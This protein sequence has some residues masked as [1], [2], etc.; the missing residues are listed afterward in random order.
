LTFANAT[1]ALL[2]SIDPSALI[3]GRPFR[4]LLDAMRLRT[5][6]NCEDGDEFMAALC[7]AEVGHPVA[8]RCKRRTGEVLDFA[9]EPLPQG[10]FIMT[11]ADISILARAEGDAQRRADLLDSILDNVPHGICVYGPDRRVTMVNRIYAEVMEGA[12]VAIGDHLDEVIRRRAE[13]GEY[14]PGDP[15][16]VTDEQ[17]AHDIGLPQMRRRRRPNGKAVDVRTAP[18]PDGG[19]ISVVTDVTDLTEAEDRASRRAEEL[20]VMLGSIRHG[21]TLWSRERTVVASNAMAS[22]LLGHP[23]G[24]LVPGRTMQEAI[25]HMVAR[26]ELGDG[27]AAAARAE[28]LAGRDWG[29]VYQRELITAAGRVLE[30]RS[31]PTPDGG[32]VSTFTDVTEARAVEQELRRAKEAAETANRAKSRFLATM[33]HELRTPLNAIIGFSDALLREAG[34]PDPVRIDEYAKQVNIAGHQLLGLINSILD[35][36]R[37]EAG[38][39]E[40]ADDLVD[41]TRLVRAAA[42]RAD[43][44]AQAAEIEL[45]V[46][47]AEGLP[48]LRA[49]ERRLSQA[50]GHLINNAIKFTEAGGTV[51]VVV[52]RQTGAADGLLI[53][54]ADTGIGIAEADLERVFEPFTQIDSSLARRF[55]G[56]GLGLYVSR[57]LVQGHGGQLVLRS[58]PGEGTTAEIRL[59]ADR[60]VAAGPRPAQEDLP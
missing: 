4:T 9:S 23:P 35:V 21:I 57:A 6:C 27:D 40:L 20:A 50:L 3:P 25:D 33:S 59:P 60:L 28:T 44:S 24:V 38:R 53:S 26:G 46:E 1:F 56:S 11:V 29:D 47:L 39:F 22:E 49:D 31:D 36:S 51:T 43:A 34:N 15:A 32:F 55:D 2:L 17:R 14:G 37:I 12:P 10:G 5:A 58:R 42:R 19:H 45:F 18:L 30:A 16:N 13:A 54:V 41:L 7:R 48:R 52:A 8:L